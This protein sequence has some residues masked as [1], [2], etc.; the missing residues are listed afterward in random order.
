MTWCPIKHWLY[1]QEHLII[2]SFKNRDKHW[3]HLLFC[4]DVANENKPRQFHIALKKNHFNL[5]KNF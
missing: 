3:D 4:T 5:C 1:L 2:N